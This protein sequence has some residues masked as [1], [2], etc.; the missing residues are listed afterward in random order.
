MQ[1]KLCHYKRPAYPPH[2]RP[3]GP[4]PY[5][6]K[7]NPESGSAFKPL[8]GFPLPA[9]AGTGPAGMTAKEG[10]DFRFSGPTPNFEL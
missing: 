3:H 2:L 1:S 9:F 4:N 10:L 5:R 6:G 8:S 7:A